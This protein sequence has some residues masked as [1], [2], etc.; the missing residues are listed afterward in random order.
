M[1]MLRRIG[2]NLGLVYRDDGSWRFLGQRTPPAIAP[3]PDRPVSR[4]RRGFDVTSH[5]VEQAGRSLQIGG[6]GRWRIGW[7]GRQKVKAG[8]P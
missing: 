7:Q 3:R 5:P 8:R 2:Q 1:G 4:L 6:N